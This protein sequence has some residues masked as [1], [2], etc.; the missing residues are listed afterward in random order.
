MNL[1]NNL[2]QARK[3]VGLSQETVAEKLGVSRQTVSKWETDET[4]PDIYQ[5]KKLAK[6]YNLTLDELIE[7]D[8]DV[9]EIE[10]VIKNTNEEKE[11]KINWTNAWSKKYPVLST[12]QNEVDISKYAFEIRSMLSSL[13]KEYGFNDLDSMLVLKDILY[14]EWKD[15]KLQFQNYFIPKYRVIFIFMI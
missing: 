9:K 5:A 15:N 1:G 10:E 6:L 7:F 8:I 2:F 4:V 11:A 12:Y 3:K 14:H 13:S